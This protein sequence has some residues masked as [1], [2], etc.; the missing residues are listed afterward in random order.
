MKTSMHSDSL[1]PSLRAAGLGLT[2]TIVSFVVAQNNYLL[3]HTIAE[4]F[5]LLVAVLIYVVGTR[6]YRYSKDSFLLFLGNAY[7]FVAI[8]DFFHTM[9]YQGMGVFPGYTANVPTQLWIAGRYLGAASLLLATFFIGR[10]FPRKTVF[11]LYAL[12]T[13]GLI[14]SILVIPVFPTAFVPGQGLTPFKIASEYAISLL[15]AGAILHLRSHRRE[16]DKSMYL[17]MSAAMGITILSEFSFTLYTDVYGVMNLVGHL[18]KVL[19]YYLVF[20][21]I[22]QRGLDAPY[23]E[24]KRLNEGLEQR[25]QERTGQLRAVLEQQE[26]LVRMVSHD[27]RSP[28]TAVQGQAQLLARMLKR[29]EQ[30]APLLRSAESIVVSARRM[31]SMIQDLVDMARMESNQMQ[32]NRVP[33]A[34]RDYLLELERRLEGV[35][36]ID[37]L[38]MDIAEDLPRVFAD[39]DRLERIFTNLLSNALKYSSSDTEVAVKVEVVDGMVKISVIDRGPGIGPDD[40]P[41]MFQRYYRA[42]GTRRADGLGLGLYITRMLVESHGGRIWVDSEVGKGSTFSFTLPVSQQT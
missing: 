2:I 6:T 42:M 17:L 16:L 22:V 25:V 14:A 13:A 23:L 38:R 37:R 21:G 24:V 33:I 32:L 5:A 31:N 18:F 28:L 3:F 34:L 40:L 35:F 27:L 8:L 41:N 7:L 36:E 20:L 26:D 11:S 9:T 4:G 29:S 30:G 39:P 12:L 15:L 19:A 1:V 10:S